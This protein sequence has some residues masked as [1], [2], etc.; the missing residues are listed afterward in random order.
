MKP[1]NSKTRSNSDQGESE[2]SWH[3]FKRWFGPRGQAEKASHGDELALEVLEPRILYSAAPVEAAPAEEAPVDEAAHVAPVSVSDDGALDID[4]ADA[5]LSQAESS[6]A[7]DAP[8]ES[9]ELISGALEAQ[10]GLSLAVGEVEA[11][12]LVTDIP[13]P[14]SADDE[15][16]FLL[17]QADVE[18]LAE[19]AAKRWAETGLT[20][21]Q[22]AALGQV[23][24]Q[25]ADL[26]ENYLGATEGFVIT[27]DDDAAGRDWFV[28]ETADLDE[29][30]SGSGTRLI[31]N[32]DS[33]GS[34][35]VD[36]LSILIHEQGHVLGLGDIDR[37]GSESVMHGLFE[38]GERRVAFDGEAEGAEAGSLEGVHY[39]TLTWDG[40]PDGGVSSADGNWSTANNWTGD[41]DVPDGDDDLIFS[42]TTNTT[43][44]NDLAAG[45]AIVGIQFTNT[46]TGESFILGGNDIQLTG[47]I[48]STAAMGAITEEISLNIQLTDGDRT[49]NLG[50]DHDL[51]IFGIIT[52]D[53]TDRQLIKSGAGDLTLTVANSYGGGTVI[54]GSGNAAI[55]VQHNDALGMGTVT[56]QGSN[57]NLR[58]GNG[59]TVFNPLFISDSGNDKRISLEGGTTNTAAY[60]GPITLEEDDDGN[61]E[62]SPAATTANASGQVLTISGKIS[63]GSKSFTATEDAIKIVSDGTVVISNPDND[64]VGNIDV[65]NNG[66]TLRVVNDAALSNASIRLDNS[67]TH[68]EIAA[69]VNNVDN[70]IEVTDQGDAKRIKLESG[71]GNS[72]T[73]LS[74]ITVLETGNGNFE[75]NANGTMDFDADQVLTVAGPI[76][77][78]AGAGVEINGDGIVE[79]ANSGNDITG[80]ISVTNRGSA[81]RIL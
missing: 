56:L 55:N 75:L 38:E 34:D 27:I 81:L 52:D 11:I 13:E 54:N 5:L 73:L 79:L 72:A 31:A 80:T 19:E 58:L 20:E 17:T 48:T 16:E 26:G 6:F 4:S 66:S 14:V 35:G 32:P 23:T 9:G 78:T 37:S 10:E 45:T 47:N 22:L 25:I 63:N 67:N 36:L 15:G 60:A 3:R 62:L 69:G 18:N 24:Y 46:G 39:A 59:I 76:T 43:T 1:S 21:E 68:L 74:P 71:T 42:G 29:E 64:F 70:T 33:A 8:A 28:D 7:P 53:G 41:T 50:A 57:A 12:A 61:F 51:V 2:R 65:D 30:F 49:I 40:A 44:N 77:S